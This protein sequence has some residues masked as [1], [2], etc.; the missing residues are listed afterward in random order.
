MRDLEKLKKE[1]HERR[2]MFCRAAKRRQIAD[3]MTGLS[4][5]SGSEELR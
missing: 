1:K 5:G 3:M 2:R 4:N